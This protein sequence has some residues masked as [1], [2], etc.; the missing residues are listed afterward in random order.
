MIIVAFGWSNVGHTGSIFG[1]MIGPLGVIGLLIGGWQVYIRGRR[2]NAVR[3]QQASYAEQ[4]EAVNYWRDRPTKFR[5]YLDFLQKSQ[6]DYRGAEYIVQLMLDFRCMT[7]DQANEAW[8]DIRKSENEWLQRS[9]KRLKKVFDPVRKDQADDEKRRE[10]ADYV[11]NHPDQLGTYLGYLQRNER[12]FRGAVLMVRF[13]LDFGV[14]DRD[15]AEKDWEEISRS[16]TRYYMTLPAVGDLFRGRRPRRGQSPHLSAGHEVEMSRVRL[17]QSDRE[18]EQRQA[19]EQLQEEQNDA[20][21][22]Q[23]QAQEQ[24]RT[25]QDRLNDQLEVLHDR[26][27]R[28]K[29]QPREQELIQQEERQVVTRLETL[30]EEASQIQR[31]QEQARLSMQQER[32]DIQQERLSL[33]QE[34]VSLQ[35]ERRSFTLPRLGHAPSDPIGRAPPLGNDSEPTSQQEQPRQPPASRTTWNPLTWS[36]FRRRRTQEPPRQQQPHTQGRERRGWSSWF[37]DTYRY[38]TNP[39]RW[40][41]GRARGV[42]GAPPPLESDVEAQQVEQRPQSRQHDL[43]TVQ[44]SSLFQQYQ[45]PASSSSQQHPSSTQQQPSTGQDPSTKDEITQ[46]RGNSKD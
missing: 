20:Q 23:Q 8:R 18:R 32:L 7:Q 13:A 36:L 33:Q 28:L 15:R 22:R 40:A 46:A 41:M 10:V 1:G 12:D 35:Q 6:H 5:G 2:I 38:V 39:V 44:S 31:E 11:R 9:G 29:G 43:H 24:L 26:Y 14:I 16:E 42:H 21:Q 4:Q 34:R 19:S 27:R 3:K 17:R 37:T 30:H 45:P 25:E